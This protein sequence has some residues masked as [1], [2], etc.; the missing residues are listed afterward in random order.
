MKDS[1]NKVAKLLT[2]GEADYL[3]FN[4]AALRYKHTAAVKSALIKSYGANTTN[5]ILCA[6]RRVLKEALRLELISPTD[7]AR[8]V[9]IENVKVS[10]ELRGRALSQY[11]I[12]K[13]FEVCF[14][15]R[16]PAGFRDAAILSILCGAGLRRAETTNLDLK[17]F[18]SSGELKIRN[19][20]GR[21]DR[22]VYLND[23]ACKLVADWIEIRTSFPGALL[24]QISRSGRV[25]KKQLTPQSVLFILQKRGQEAGLEHFSPH[26]M[27]RTYVSELLD[28]GV[29]LPTVQS[30]A[31]HS[32]PGITARYD[33]RGDD[34]KRRAAATLHV[35]VR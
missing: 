30:L 26:D 31:G 8:A 19:G 2:N 10:K 27:R 3:T 35:P 6:L 32:N 24:T 34:R 12:D 29:D 13:L 16:T 21:I 14:K 25:I 28:A 11:E 22:T 17:D 15:D 4:W 5:R 1:L 23:G 33:R 9:D 20:K 7:Y 18:N